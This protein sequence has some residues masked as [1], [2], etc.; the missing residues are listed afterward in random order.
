[1]GC[2]PR[3]GV[4]GGGEGSS[5]LSY[6]RSPPFTMVLNE[7]INHLRLLTVLI[8]LA[9][10]LV[11]QLFTVSASQAINYSDCRQAVTSTKPR[12]RRPS[13]A[14][15]WFPEENYERALPDLR[16]HPTDEAQGMA[17]SWRRLNPDPK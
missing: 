14:Q 2:S 4:G 3:C 15:S 9:L 13:Q 1:M 17:S 16:L 12:R 6:Y 10:E 7:P 11:E 8:M 5:P